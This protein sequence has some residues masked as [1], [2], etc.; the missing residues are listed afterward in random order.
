KE[1]QLNPILDLARFIVWPYLRR[2]GEE[3]VVE[4]A[5]TGEVRQFEDWS[6][7]EA[8]YAQGGIHPLDLKNAVGEYLIRMLEPASTSS[9]ARARSTWR[10]CSPS[11]RHGEGAFWLPSSSCTAYFGPSVGRLGPSCCPTVA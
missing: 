4:N 9:T 8:D 10:K 3:L 2:V 6:T 11:R 5:K 1:T 7:F